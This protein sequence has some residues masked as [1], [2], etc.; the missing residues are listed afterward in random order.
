M[1]KPKEVQIFVSMPEYTTVTVGD[2]IAKL[3]EFPTE[4]PACFTWEGQVIAVDLDKISKSSKE[5][6][7]QP[8]VLIDAE[9]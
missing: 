5:N 3:A 8:I 1:S 2:L 9:N 7:F 4:M 6:L